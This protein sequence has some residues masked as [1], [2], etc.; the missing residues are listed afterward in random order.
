MK[1]ITIDFSPEELQA[2]INLIEYAMKDITIS[3]EPLVEIVYNKFKVN[4]DFNS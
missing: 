1:A 3:D 4:L 2:V